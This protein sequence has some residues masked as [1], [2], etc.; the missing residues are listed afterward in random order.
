MRLVCG[1]RWWRRRLGRERCPGMPRDRNICRL[2]SFAAGVLL[3]G[4]VSSALVCDD[5]LAFLAPR[6]PTQKRRRAPSGP[7]DI[8]KRP[9]EAP[10]RPPRGSPTPPGRP[11][12]LVKHGIFARV[13]LPA[14]PQ[15]GP[16]GKHLRKLRGVWGSGERWRA[17]RGPLGGLSEGS[18]RKIDV[19][20]MQNVS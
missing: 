18:S 17:S 15:E 6:R 13:A 7:Q 8:T 14:R 10:K 3:R 16:R 12:N 5:A 20:H 4:K 9:Q 11:N 19:L 1:H 2:P